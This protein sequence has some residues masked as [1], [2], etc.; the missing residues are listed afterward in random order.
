MGKTKIINLSL[1]IEAQQAMKKVQGLSEE[2]NNMPIDKNLEPRLKKVEKTLDG[3]VQQISTITDKMDVLAKAGGLDPKTLSEFAALAKS[4]SDVGIEVDALKSKFNNFTKSINDVSDVGIK[5]VAE[6]ITEEIG[7]MSTNIDES[8]NNATTSIQK[9]GEKLKKAYEKLLVSLQSSINKEVLDISKIVKFSENDDYDDKLDKIKERIDNDL[10]ELSKSIQGYN[11]LKISGASGDDFVE[12]IKQQIKALD[13][14]KQSVNGFLRAEEFDAETDEYISDKAKDAVEIIQSIFPELKSVA[15][16]T[17]DDLG[18]LIDNIFDSIH[19]NIKTN[20]NNIETSIN[21]VEKVTNEVNNGKSTQKKPNKSD[22]EKTI[23]VGIKEGVGAE[24]IAELKTVIGDLQK[25]VDKNPVELNAVIN[26]TWGTKQTQ[27]YLKSIRE[28]LSKTKNGKIDENLAARIY[29]LQDAFGKDFS[30]ALNKS[31]SKLKDSLQKEGFSVG[32]LKIEDTAVKDFREQISNEIGAITVDI[33]ANIL[34]T[35]VVDKD[36]TEAVNQQFE[37]LRALDKLDP[38]KINDLVK[39][40][41]STGADLDYSDIYKDR[42][43]QI[44]KGLVDGVY[45][46]VPE[47]IA[48]TR[49]PQGANPLIA[50]FNTNV[51]RLKDLKARG[52][53]EIS[54]GELAYIKTQMESL[55][56][57][58]EVLS[59]KISQSS[60]ESHDTISEEIKEASQKIDSA[61]IEVTGTATINLNG[62]PKIVAEKVDVETKSN[63]KLESNNPPVNADIKPNSDTHSLEKEFEDNVNKLSELQ[64]EFNETIAEDPIKASEINQVIQEITTRQLELYNKISEDVSDSDDAKNEVQNAEQTIKNATINVSDANISNPTSK[65]EQKK[66]ANYD[67]WEYFKTKIYSQKEIKTYYKSPAT[68]KNIQRFVNDVINSGIEKFYIPKTYQDN[69]VGQYTYSLFKKTNDPRFVLSEDLVNTTQEKET[70]SKTANEVQESTQAVKDAA[71]STRDELVRLANERFKELISNEND[72]EAIDFKAIDKFVGDLRK[73]DIKTIDPKFVNTTTGRTVDAMLKGGYASALEAFQSTASHSEEA[74]AKALEAQQM[75]KFF[76]RFQK[77]YAMQTMQEKGTGSEKSIQMFVDAVRKSGIDFKVN[78]KYQ[79]NEIGQ[80]VNSMLTSG[81]KTVAEAI[82]VRDNKPIDQGG[83]KNIEN[84][85]LNVT[86]LTI[87]GQQHI[88]EVTQKITSA[89]ITITKGNIS[90]N[91]TVSEPVNT[92]KKNNNIKKEKDDKS[93][94][95]I[96][97]YNN[98]ISNR[99]N[100]SFGDYLLKQGNLLSKILNNNIKVKKKDVSSIESYQQYID[101][102]NKILDSTTDEVLKKKLSQIKAQLSSD[103]EMVN[104][105]VSKD[106][107]ETIQTSI[108]D[109]I[110]NAGSVDEISKTLSAKSSEIDKFLKDIDKINKTIKKNENLNYSLASQKVVEDSQTEITQLK[111][112]LENAQKNNDYSVIDTEK[113]SDRIKELQSAIKTAVDDT[114]VKQ[115]DVQGLIRKLDNLQIDEVKADPEIITEVKG[116]RKKLQAVV[117]NDAQEI[118][119]EQ[120]NEWVKQVS[121]L[122]GTVSKSDRTIFGNFMKELRHKNYQALAQ[123]FSLNDII[124]Y[125]R[126]AISVIKQYDTA[127]IE[128]MKVSDETRSSLE[129]Y[130]ETLFDTADAIGSAALTLEKSTADWMRIGESLTE[131]AKS[132]QAAQ[133]LMNVSEFQ[134]IDEA[135]QALVSASQA[136]ADL[137][138]MDIVDKINK[139]GNEFPIATDQL[140]TALQNSAAALTTQGNDLNE[141]LALVVGG[142]VITQDALKTGTGIR[143]IALRIAGTKEAK[144]ELAE[145]G[146]G[147]DDFVVRTESKTRKLIMD[148]TAVASN[149]FKGVDIYDANGNLR[150]TYQILQDIADI[151][152]EIQLEDRQAGTNRANAL[153]ELLA[154]KNRSNIAASILT[155]PDTIREAYEAAQNAEGSAM[156]ENEK[157][158]TSVEAHITKFKNAVDELINSLIDSGFI[159]D[160]IDFGTTLVKLLQQI[161]EGLGSVG[162]AFAAIGITAAFKGQALTKGGKGIVN[163]VKTA[164]SSVGTVLTET[165]VRNPNFDLSMLANN[166]LTKEAAE[167]LETLQGINEVESAAPAIL[168]AKAKADNIAAAATAKHAAA[169][170]LL[171]GGLVAA[172]VVIVTVLIA[173]Y[174]KH[175]EEIEKNKKAVQELASESKKQIDTLKDYAKKIADARKV[176]ED[177]RSSTEEIINA[178]NSLIDI[179]NELNDTYSEYN[180]IIKDV[181]ASIEE[182]NAALIRNAILSNNEVLN[183]ARTTETGDHGRMLDEEARLMLEHGTY[184]FGSIDSYGNVESI[185]NKYAADL[186]WTNE[187]DNQKYLTGDI[188]KLDKI[189]EVINVLNN[190]DKS[191]FEDADI[192]RTIELL[193]NT[194]DFIQKNLEEY[195]DIYLAQGFDSS[196]RQYSTEFDK[197]MND[198]YKHIE[199]NTDETKEALEASILEIWEQA[200]EDNNLASMYWIQNFFGNYSDV[201]NK[202]ILDSKLT[203]VMEDGVT[204][205]GEELLRVASEVHNN[206][207]KFKTIVNKATQALFGQDA[208]EDISNSTAPLIDR[209]INSLSQSILGRDII[210]DKVFEA[211]SYQDALGYLEGTSEGKGISPQAIKRLNELQTLIGEMGLTAKEALD[212]LKEQGVFLDEARADLE[213]QIAAARNRAI[214]SGIM[215]GEQFDSLGIDTSDKLDAWEKKVEKTATSFEQASQMFNL[216]ISGVDKT[217]DASTM[218]KNMEDQYKPVFDAM[219]EAYKAIWEDNKFGGTEKVTADQIEAVRSQMEALS[220]KLKEAGSEGFETDDINEFILTLSDAEATEKEVQDAFN[221]LATVLVDSLNPELG[222]ASAAT[223]ELIQKT[224][225]DMGVTNAAEVTFGRLGYTLEQYNAAKEEADKNDLDLDASIGSLNAEQLA[226]IADN[227]ALMTY[228]GSRVLVDSFD[229]NTVDDVKA[230]VNLA[231]ALGLSTIGSLKLADAQKYLGQMM[232]FAQLAENAQTDK[233]RDYY[234]SLMEREMAN[235]KKNAEYSVAVEYDGNKARSSSDK[236]GSDSKQKFDWIERAIKKIQRA[237]TNLGKVADATYKSW[238]ERLDAIM[239][240]TQEFHDEIGRFGQ[241]NIDLYN[242]PQYINEDGSIST[243]RSM[244]FGDEFGNEILVPTIA[245]DNNGNPY[246]MSDDEA[247]ARYYETGEYLGLFKSVEEAEEYAEKLH[248]Q[249]DALYVSGGNSFYAGKYQKLKEE[250]ALQEQ[251]AQ[252]YMQEANA[253]GLAAEYKNKVMNGMMDIETISDET[254]KEQISDFQEYYDKATDAADAVE[255][256][257]GELAQLAQVKFDMITKQFEEMALAIDHAATRIGHIQS[258]ISS[259]GYFE[260]STLIEQLLFGDKEKLSQLEDEARQLAASIDE[261]VANGDI[262]YGSEQWWGMYDSLQNVNDQIV[263]MK[264]SMADLNDQLRQMDW[265]RFDYI[266]DSIERLRTEND[267]LIDTLE[268]ENQLFEK[269]QLMN[270]DIMVSNGNWTDTATAIQG[271]RVNNLEI[272]KQ[273]NEEVAEEIKKVNADL[274]N[275]PNNKKLLERR[276]ALIDQQQDIIKGITQEKQS[277]KSLIQEGYETFLNYLQKSIDKRKEALRAEKNLYDYQRTVSDQTKTITDYRKQLAALSGG[278]DSEENRARLQQLKDDLTKAEKDL[279][280]TEYERWLTDQEEMMDSMYESF[281]NLINEKLDDLEGLIESAIQQT[282][283]NSDSIAKTIGEQADE[284]IYDLDNTSFGVNFDARI[285]DAVTAVNA[286]ENAINTMIEA[287]NVNAQN[288][289]AQLQ[290][291]AQTIVTQAQVQAQEIAQVYADMSNNG[292]DNGS[293]GTKENSVDPSGSTT[294]K[295][296]GKTLDRSKASATNDRGKANTNKTTPN[297]GSE[298]DEA[299][300]MFNYYKRLAESIGQSNSMYYTYTALAADWYEKYKEALKKA[301]FAKGGTIG[302]AVKST[303]EDGIILARTGEEVL[304]LERIKQ[305]QGIFKMMQPLAALGTNKTISN[306]GGTTTV[307]GMNVSFELPNVTS[308]EDFV[309]QAKSDPTFEKLVQN[310]TIGTALG[311]SKL[312]KY[313]L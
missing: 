127:L 207:N 295:T 10:S 111:T 215:T 181:N 273:Q 71:L 268:T 216:A 136:Y 112:E 224:L 102:I 280:D 190:L 222:A 53:S 35:T 109:I 76:E 279:Q 110:E 304:S 40:I 104:K 199:Q 60:G 297:K 46:S 308:Y 158:L 261:A 253:I 179:Q 152:K 84:A 285:S 276:N 23:T 61:T 43:K 117:D 242:R 192:Q 313:S 234:N 92:E 191:E 107:A 241:G 105:S 231:E 214:E 16:S 278:T 28:Q 270:T 286:V 122:S 162:T 114:V 213:T 63:E 288:E 176:L 65:Q 255:D 201:I 235:F 72:N 187:L 140:A 36:K 119:E 52:E 37:E 96:D 143:T 108:Q 289:L 86:N 233:Q 153:V 134:S 206:N 99:G 83:K 132:A 138:K 121:Q 156:Q 74:K 211:V 227:E 44:V 82:A 263:E 131:A 70:V 195:G 130:Q 8:I 66:T 210:S 7:N 94:K 306:I 27:K 194:K 283:D 24:L 307:N 204:T 67:F 146:E 205:Y 18:D 135:T 170:N 232:H 141:A 218:L 93:Q 305:M 79:D 166:G 309:R 69:A 245:F 22:E 133:I 302:S 147:V 1:A 300:D 269:V 49:Y 274:A 167:Y 29:G 252:A 9:G 163:L 151:Y 149:G 54:E 237:V 244:S 198:Y 126:E 185:L 223:A 292:G 75:S 243:V 145:L 20:L 55:K 4:I 180:T 58:Q 113:I 38:G 19:K 277:I 168:N 188:N 239:G 120:Y 142:N 157:Y 298:A 254:L 256:L 160:V 262:E 78:P 221:N 101:K 291:L 312:S 21:E 62:E 81:Y 294:N 77:L 290:A 3:V 209:F 258:K 193:N 212:Y 173:A 230:L 25:Y 32:K 125:M 116:L 14:L 275:D 175:Q 13:K 284:F 225:T 15:S 301:K 80:L 39:T 281:E 293:G 100:E 219:A 57:R 311:K 250:I 272:L 103:Y 257:R 271:L 128:M 267:F 150:S 139:L 249:Q 178:K 186:I 246:S 90:Q 5:K 12:N 45:G 148:Y 85:T 118:T 282:K 189:T 260:S 51:R 137:D 248:E 47:A 266:Q 89:N 310:I 2:L 88:Q 155:N 202:A 240:K 238:G 123:F 217:L 87:K 26:P 98:N 171:K 41:K 265:D 144:D 251:A 97:E 68:E 106:N 208:F 174:K 197:V 115:I 161:T 48:K 33:N 73:A 226:L 200:S 95:I 124:R 30:E 64:K 172:A 264:S 17:F 159:N 236:T 59:A 287:A 129:K 56:K 165:D 303:G 31:I 203:Q 182:Q 296:A 177:E 50:E 164:F 91:T 169:M 11:D 228:Y 299:L 259:E 220:G 247:I 6:N 34:G 229:I 183:N 196:M 42:L 154:G 184:T